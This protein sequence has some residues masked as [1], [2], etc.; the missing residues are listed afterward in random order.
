MD[1]FPSFLLH[2]AVGLGIWDA[3]STAASAMLCEQTPPTAILDP[4]DR[5]IHA[6][7]Q[8]AACR[9]VH[10]GTHPDLMVLAPEAM[11]PELGLAI[12]GGAES[13][14][15]GEKRSPSKDI[16]I[17]AIRQLVDW[18]HGTS[19][20]G[21][22][23]VAL[24]YPLDAM[25]PPAANALL[26][27][28][29]EPS[30]T[31]YFLTGTHHLHRILPT[32]R[33]RC[34][35]K[36]MPRLGQDEALRILQERGVADPKG[37]ANWCRNAV[38]GADPGGG[39]DW[40]RNLL[41]VLTTSGKDPQCVDAIGTLPPLPIAITALQKLNADLLRTQFGQRPIYLPADAAAL[42]GLGKRAGAARLHDF[43]KRLAKYGGSAHFPLHAGLTAD[44]LIL[45]FKQLFPRSAH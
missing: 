17:D 32:L 8:C 20:R 44:A 42:A 21:G 40:V 10:A 9:L 25:A 16:S 12:A 24:I 45:E 14:T 1:D 6:C 41:G 27:I 31:L 39:L 37:V 11:A 35:L 29:E 3:L 13:A 26:K 4:T 36:P 30:A 23:K 38:H 18:A 19:H 28:L 2:G 7:G 43:W 34:R 33:S 15:S 22:L 5:N